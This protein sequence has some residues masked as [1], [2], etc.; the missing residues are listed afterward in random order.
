M[1]DLKKFA[2][3]YLDLMRENYDF[4]ADL[5]YLKTKGEKP[6]TFDIFTYA[7]CD[8]IDIALILDGYLKGST[9]ETQVEA[10]DYLLALAEK[11]TQDK[12]ITNDRHLSLV[13]N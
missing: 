8:P 2:G 5:I 4:E 1:F 10:V 7:K 9:F 12:N 11:Y 13:R 6:G 3:K